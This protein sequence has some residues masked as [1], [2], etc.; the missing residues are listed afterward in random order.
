M[1]TFEQTEA[2]L[3]RSVATHNGCAPDGEGPVPTV[4]VERFIQRRNLE[5]LR[6]RLMRTDDEEEYQRIVKR[7]GEGEAKKSGR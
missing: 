1:V 5:V 4:S 7:I 6:A 3:K 2:P